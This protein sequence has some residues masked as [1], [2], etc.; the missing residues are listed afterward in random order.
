MNFSVWPLCTSVVTYPLEWSGER[1]W[2]EGENGLNV[3]I[4]SI[5]LVVSFWRGNCLK[6]SKVQYWEFS[7]V[8]ISAGWRINR[9][10]RI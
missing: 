4:S 10:V 3:Y 8:S 2:D 1:E 7:H 9:G 6:L 5:T